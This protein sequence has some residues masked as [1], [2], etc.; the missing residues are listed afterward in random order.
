[1][2]QHDID[3]A[4]KQRLVDLQSREQVCWLD[5]RPQDSRAVDAG[6]AQ[7]EDGTLRQA[8]DLQDQGRRT[9]RIFVAAKSEA[10]ETGKR[11]CVA[12]QRKTADRG[13]GDDGRASMKL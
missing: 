1:M 4:R 2:D 3:A 5:C 12:D 11:A 9:I 7:F 6:P 10:I 8:F 13:I